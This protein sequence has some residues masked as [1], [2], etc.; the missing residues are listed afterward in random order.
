MKFIGWY[1]PYL[2]AGVRLKE[3]N[4]D[5]TRFVTEMKL[6]LYNR[7]LFGTH[8]GGSLY[9]MTDP[10]FV[11]IVMAHLG[12]EYIVWDKAAEIEFVR[13]GRGKVRAEMAASAEAL[14]EI[15]QQADE[16]GKTLYDFYTQVTDMKGQTVA[17]VRKTIYIRKK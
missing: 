13:P 7:N 14:S 1:P 16:K 5:F 9:S 10:F 2:G 4:K 15:K 17:K 8:F 3:Y 11:F 6:R 12:D